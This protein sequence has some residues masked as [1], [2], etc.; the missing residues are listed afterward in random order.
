MNYYLTKLLS[1]ISSNK[2]YVL[3]LG[4]FKEVDTEGSVW[5]VLGSSVHM[6]IMKKNKQ[7][8]FWPRLLADKIQEKT[9]VKID[10]DRYVD[11]DEETKGFDTSSLD[12][13]MDFSSMM[14][15]MEGM[16]AGGDMDFGGDG[17]EDSDDGDDLPDLEP[18]A[19]S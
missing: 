8:S 7:E 10:W 6:K 19:S 11:E 15:G 14:G 18:A 17:E 5:N 3:D 9:N 4:F 2:N 12:G 16:G 1:G 13:G